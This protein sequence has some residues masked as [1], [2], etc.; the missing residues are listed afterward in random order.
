MPRSLLSERQLLL[1][2]NII[3]YYIAHGQAASSTVLA[4]KMK[5]QY[6]P[7]TIRNLMKA[8]KKQDLITS[9]HCS[10]GKVPT[11]KGYRI[12]VDY[13]IQPTLLTESTIATVSGQLDFEQD[14]RSLLQSTTDL[15][16]QN[17][18]YIGLVIPPQ[19]EYLQLKQIEFLQL[20]PQRILAVLVL[21]GNEIQHRIL[22]TEKPYEREELQEFANFLNHHYRGH[23]LQSMRESLLATIE[24]EHKNLSYY[25]MSL[26]PVLINSL[27]MNKLKQPHSEQKLLISMN[28]PKLTKT[29]QSIKNLEQ[30]KSILN[31]LEKCIDA[32]SIQIF[33]GEEIGNKELAE[34]SL[35]ATSFSAES[36]AYGALGILGPYA[37]PYQQIISLVT[38]TAQLLSSALNQQ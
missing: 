31:L 21:S 4:K 32:E 6:S 30:Q 8:L 22:S 5:P 28:N 16:S 35:I 38:L 14:T 19:Q 18:G 13:L 34:Y 12:F 25:L 17:T 15:L 37:M 23:S 9:P 26:L 10:A 2:K 11:S 24:K 29:Q 7:A 1:L 33:I 3:E 27:A 20:S 36:A